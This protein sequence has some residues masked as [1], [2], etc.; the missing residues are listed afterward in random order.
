MA[1]F[2]QGPKGERGLRGEPGPKGDEGDPGPVGER[3]ADGRDGR[4]GADGDPGPE[5]RQ[6]P[7][8]TVTFPESITINV[9]HSGSV[10][11]LPPPAPPA[12][13]RPSL[14]FAV[15][16]IGVDG[17]RG[18]TGLAVSIA[19][20][21]EVSM[22]L[23]SNEAVK[24]RVDFPLDNRGAQTKGRVVLGTPSDPNVVAILTPPPTEAAASFEF[25]IAAA[26]AV[27]QPSAVLGSGV[28][29]VVQL[30]QEDGD[31]LPSVP[32]ITLVHDIVSQEAQTAT[33]TEGEVRTIE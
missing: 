7:P 10:T 14:T 1:I 29:T 17:R 33:I 2:G 19:E 6:G 18:G 22:Q 15:F 21:K 5:G 24:Y 25:E 13:T 11:V 4:A 28:T 9:V 20:A 12:P 3:G 30:L 8:G 16:A 23:R 31:P 27:R 32:D 26:L